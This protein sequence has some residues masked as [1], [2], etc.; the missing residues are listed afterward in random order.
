MS[1]DSIS[2]LVLAPAFAAVLALVSAPALA[3]STVEAPLAN[4]KRVTRASAAPVPPASTPAIE[5]AGPAVPLPDR[6]PTRVAA[7]PA[8]TA[9]REAPSV[10]LPVPKPDLP[11]MTVFLKPVVNYKL[12]DGDKDRLKAAVRASY[13]GSFGDARA[14]IRAI[15]DKS[16][17]KVALWYYYRGKNTDASPAELE[18]FRKA[19]PDWP[20][21]DRIRRNAEMNLLKGKV[22]PKAVI[23]FFEASPPT[24]GLGKAALATAQL[25]LGNT[26]RA[27]MLI[28]QAWR[29]TDIDEETEG[30][31][32]S[33]FS[34]LLAAS[35]HKARIDRL[36]LA[37]QSR[38]T[39]AAV[40][41][42]KLLDETEQKKVDARVAVVKRS[43]KAEDL[44][45]NISADAQQNDI[46]FYFSR[47]Q[48]L[49]RKD[50]GEEA[51]KLLLSAPTEPDALVSISDWWIER[52]V[53]CRSALDAGK[54]QI[55]YE[56]VRGLGP[57]KGDAYEEAQFLAGWI[58]LRYLGQPEDAFNHFVA[59]RTAAVDDAVIS[60]AEYW[61]GRTELVRRNAADAEL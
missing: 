47:I 36:L 16:A 53:N 18:A 31:V 24:T 25:S 12:S 19:N 56:L 7:T 59:L 23:A 21:G 58:A 52:R 45:K 13:A 14:A 37:D 44:L 4:P 54:P 22:E 6:K 27:L 35:D 61:L 28:R 48:N 33:R 10:S 15:S 40:R 51:W 46:G 57:L 30:E 50:K 32:L 39:E 3:Q 38:L 41:T 20:Q 42:A 8:A 11:D 55:A 49:R 1:A 2:R 60:R 43:S 34:K 9:A 29:S 26:E 17:Q 5:K